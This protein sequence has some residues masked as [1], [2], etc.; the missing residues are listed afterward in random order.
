[1][2]VFRKY[3]GKQMPLLSYKLLAKCLV[4]LRWDF[5]MLFFVL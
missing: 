5:A 3:R 4:L 1:M 2:R